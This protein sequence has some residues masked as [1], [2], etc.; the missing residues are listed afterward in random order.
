M[1]TENKGR[2]G[3]RTVPF[4]L[5]PVV[6]CFDL[7]FKVVRE[8]GA[9]PLLKDKSDLL[10]QAYYDLACSI[11]DRIEDNHRVLSQEMA[12]V[13]RQQWEK[14]SSKVEAAHLA[15][16]AI[17]KEEA[18]AAED[19]NLARRFCAQSWSDEGCKRDEHFKIL[20][21]KLLP[22]VKINKVT[23]LAQTLEAAATMHR[24]E[25]NEDFV[26]ARK[27]LKEAKRKSKR[28]TVYAQ[29]GK[30]ARSKLSQLTNLSPKEMMMLSDVSLRLAATDSNKW[31]AD[32][33]ARAGLLAAS[34]RAFPLYAYAMRD[35]GIA[36]RILD[37]EFENS[38]N[39]DEGV[40]R[41]KCLLLVGAG[42]GLFLGN[43]C[44]KF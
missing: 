11:C 38:K 42:R 2:E 19:E 3:Y 40:K 36:Q 25:K 21:G 32:F 16:D 23:E 22:R 26:S 10:V 24:S 41:E 43:R 30:E 29:V 13:E 7:V 9:P 5:H 12:L 44:R 33:W 39:K 14:V 31:I 18:C 34:Q 8:I 27:K 28:A 37:A 6:S 4:F 20:W 15:L 35:A 17:R 1:R